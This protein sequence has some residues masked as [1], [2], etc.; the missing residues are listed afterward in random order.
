M[1]NPEKTSSHCLQHHGAKR[2]GFPLKVGIIPKVKESNPRGLREKKETIPG[3]SSFNLLKFMGKQ[4]KDNYLAI[5]CDLFGMVKGPIQRLLCDL[6]LGD[7]KV[8]N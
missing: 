2:L 1:A 3:D 7:E 8:T 6:Q 5:L 4:S